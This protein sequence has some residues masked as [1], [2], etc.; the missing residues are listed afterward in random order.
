MLHPDDREAFEARGIEADRQGE[1][2]DVYRI[3]CRDGVARWFHGIGRR[4]SVPGESPHMWQGVTIPLGEDPVTPPE[5]SGLA[6]TV[7]VARAAGD[8][9]PQV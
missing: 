5:P 8:A 4:V 6:P 3:I 2:E 1:W 9:S 7:P